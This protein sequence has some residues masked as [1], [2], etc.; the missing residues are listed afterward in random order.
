MTI[1]GSVQQPWV[2]GFSLVEVTLAL[3]IVSF[4]LVAIVGLL[5]VGLQTAKASREHAAAAASV[6]QIARALEGAV[7]D[8]NGVYRGV[9]VLDGLTWVSDG[10]EVTLG[11]LRNL[12]LGGLP[13]DQRIDE[14]L[15]AYV[16][17]DPPGRLGS[18]D[19]AGSALVTVAW[20]NQAEWNPST[21]TWSNDRGS[22]TTR[23]I[24]LPNR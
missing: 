1:R 7:A 8:E 9:G 2:A 11:P 16:V 24:F 17:I 22:L 18:G 10:P 5:P 14:R 6:E 4:C 3:G 12:S 20:P 15:V 21:S 23:V 13:T 19:P